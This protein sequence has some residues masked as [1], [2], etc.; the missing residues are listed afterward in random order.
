MTRRTGIL[1]LLVMNFVWGGSYAV[2]KWALQYMPPAT[3]AMTRFLIGGIVLYALV[4]RPRPP[5]S[6]RDW[7][8][9]TLVGA[10]GIS[11]AFLLNFWGLK[12]TTATK[13]AIEV[14][15]EPIVLVLLA[16]FVLFEKVHPRTGLA[17]AI[18]LAGTILL[19]LAGKDAATLWKELVGGGELL[20]DFLILFSVALGS[21]YTVLNKPVA[22]HIGSMWATALSC[23]IGAV[24]LIPVCAWE[25]YGGHVIQWSF[26]LVSAVLFLG[27]I[28]TAL[29]FALWNRVLVDLPAGDMAVTLNVQ[30]LAGII[31]GWVWLGE[32]M[33]WLGYAGAALILAGVF[34]LSVESHPPTHDQIETSP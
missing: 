4:P 2:I 6:R 29:G 31:I 32:T 24:L 7:I 11:L 9:V 15:L 12:L 16:R 34:L 1:L 28:C 23:I 10:L 3:L 13:A 20:G 18:S 33:T 26:G 14:T 17:L 30:P 8:G 21:I 5:I 25:V 27:L 22:R 19:L